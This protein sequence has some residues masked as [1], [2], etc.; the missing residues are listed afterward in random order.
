MCFGLLCFLSLLIKTSLSQNTQNYYDLFY[1]NYI[2]AQKDLTIYKEKFS[3]DIFITYFS[4]DE[5]RSKFFYTQNYGNLPN[6]KI[7]FPN[8]N[9]FKLKVKIQPCLNKNQKCCEGLAICG[10]DIVDLGVPRVQTSEEVIIDSVNAGGDMDIAWIVNGFLP[11]CHGDFDDES[12]GVFLEI[13]RPG[14]PIILYDKK[15][16]TS[17]TSGYKTEYLSTKSLCAG[18]YD[19]FFVFRMRGNY[20]LLYVKP[21][22]VENPSCVCNPV[23]KKVEG[24]NRNCG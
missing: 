6:Y 15:I 19:I 7:A 5:L 9:Y 21:F 24:S 22:F 1:L 14:D 16:I 8:E 18:R 11:T 10:N 12:C 13:H 3:N 23:T 4:T 17:I 2:K 20:N